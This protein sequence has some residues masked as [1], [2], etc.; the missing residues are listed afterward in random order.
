MNKTKAYKLLTWIFLCLATITYIITILLLFFNKSTTTII[1]L[2]TIGSIF[3]LLTATFYILQI[4]INKNTKN[5]KNKE[6]NQFDLQSKKIKNIEKSKP[7]TIEKT[8]TQ[9]LVTNKSKQIIQKEKLPKQKVKSDNPNNKI[10]KKENNLKIVYYIF[11]VLSII[12]LITALILLN[13]PLLYMLVIPT[14]ITLFI[15]SLI[16]YL[17]A[18]NIKNKI[19]INS[20]IETI[21]NQNNRN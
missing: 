13:I 20:L 12:N 6:E 9:A 5:P 8:K 21:K 3:L 11:L 1:I 16:N 18:K 7:T 2:Y 4:I 15:L 19:I 14:I 10:T 17:I